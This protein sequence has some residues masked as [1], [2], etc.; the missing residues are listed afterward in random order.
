MRQKTYQNGKLQR[1]RNK[2]NKITT[3]EYNFREIEKKWHQKW[4][5]NKTYKVTE[6]ENKKKF[7]VLNMFPYPSGAGLHVGHPLGYIASDI[8]ARY[9]RLNG[10][11]FTDPSSMLMSN[12]SKQQQKLYDEYL[13]ELDNIL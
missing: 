13:K 8:Y 7:Y 12:M 10:F 1:I 6:D 9:K 4:V 5:E 2:I 11:N 3:M